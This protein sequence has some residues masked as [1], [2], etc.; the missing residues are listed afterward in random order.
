MSKNSSIKNIVS[1]I[2]LIFIPYMNANCQGAEKKEIISKIVVSGNK[3]VKTGVILNRLPYKVGKKLDRSK[4][5]IAINNIYA[6][7]YFKQI[8]LEV[9]K[10]KNNKVILY[11]ILEEKKLL[12]KIEFKGNRHIKSKK[13][14]DDLNL[15]KLTTI[16]EESIRSIKKA[17]KKCM[18][19]KIII[20][21]KFPQKL[22]LTKIFQIGKPSF[23][24]YKKAQSLL[25]LVLIL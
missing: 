15:E 4:T 19:K 21:Q 6:L 8:R 18:R 11:I 16:N 22:S 7:G 9:E 3:H 1:L 12:E 5:K 23:L 14:L 10:E 20:K 25:Y 13:I 2:A 17:L 24:L